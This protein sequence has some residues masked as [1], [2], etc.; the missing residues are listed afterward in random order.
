MVAEIPANFCSKEKN[1]YECICNKKED[2]E[3]IYN[4][5]ILNFEPKLEYGKI[6]SENIKEQ[7]MIMKRFESNMKK[8]NELQNDNEPCDPLDPL[9]SNVIENSNGWNIYDKDFSRDIAYIKENVAR[10]WQN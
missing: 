3:H 1:E 6:Y 10:S 7:K 4:C 2:I 9:Y 8:K 5:T